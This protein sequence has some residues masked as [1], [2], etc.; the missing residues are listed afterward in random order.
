MKYMLML[1]DTGNR[2]DTCPFS[3]WE[4]YDKEVQDAGIYDSG[5]AL[6]ESHTATRVEI[7]A[8]G[9]RVVN[10]DGPF[11]EAREVLGGYYVIDV[12]DLDVALDWAAK[13][14]GAKDGA[15]IVIP[16]ADFEQ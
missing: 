14:P 5:Y 10:T 8:A 2:E 1:Q 12:P 6:A 13:C 11:A 15:V 4:K 9:E 16:I 3:D 7:N